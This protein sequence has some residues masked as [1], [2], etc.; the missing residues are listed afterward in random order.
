ML[1][2]YLII[3]RATEEM[4]KNQ[5]GQIMASTLFF[6]VLVAMLVCCHPVSGLVYQTKDAVITEGENISSF[7]E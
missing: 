1:V 2:I 3:F 4:R 5:L 6:L 7:A